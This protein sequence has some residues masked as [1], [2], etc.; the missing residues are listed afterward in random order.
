MDPNSGKIRMLRE[1]GDAV[2]HGLV[3][4]PDELLEQLKELDAAQRKAWAQKALGEL[5][6]GASESER[7]AL[8]AVAEGID[9]ACFAGLSNRHTRRRNAKL[10][11]LARKGK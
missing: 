4:I 6:K 2:A 1:P 8:K 3:P 5:R 9:P 10:N 7:R 11:R